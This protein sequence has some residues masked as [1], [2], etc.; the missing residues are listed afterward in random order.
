MTQ[1]T[2]NITVWQLWYWLKEI[3]PVWETTARQL[4]KGEWKFRVASKIHFILADLASNSVIS[5]TVTLKL[6]LYRKCS[7]SAFPR[8][9][10]LIKLIF[11]ENKIFWLSEFLTTTYSRSVVYL[12]MYHTCL[13][14]VD[15]HVG[16][17]KLIQ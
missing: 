12:Y 4:A 2:E 7:K 6:I 15:V 3:S 5:H 10:D 11:R 9:S 16:F 8:F 1:L 17:S 14:C 13:M